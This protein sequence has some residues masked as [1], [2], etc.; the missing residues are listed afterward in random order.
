VL[1][2]LDNQQPL[3]FRLAAEQGHAR[4]Q[5]NLSFMYYSGIGTPK[6]YKAAIRWY[7]AVAERGETSAQR[8]LA[9]MYRDGVGTTQDYKTGHMWFNLAAANGRVDA[10]KDRDIV[11]NKMNLTDIAIAQQMARECME[12]HP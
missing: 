1:I 11:A 9:L 7:R 10:A 8:F 12:A 3:W 2:N 5:Y 6:D 4:A